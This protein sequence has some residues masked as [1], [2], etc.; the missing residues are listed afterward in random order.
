MMR[1]QANRDQ[2]KRNQAQRTAAQVATRAGAVEGAKEPGGFTLIE[3]LVA[4]AAVGLIAVGMASLFERTGDTVRAGRRLANLNEQALMIEKTLREDIEGMS[5]GG[6]LAIQHRLAPVRG[7]DLQPAEIALNTDDRGPR[8]RRIDSIMFFREGRFTTQR[9][10]VHPSRTAVGRAARVYYGHGLPQA[11]SQANVDAYT[12]ALHDTNDDGPGM[13]RAPGFGE[14][15]P[16]EF[17]GRWILLRHET[18]L[19]P[20]RLSESDEAARGAQFPR[21]GRWADSRF[22]IAL[23]PAAGDVFRLFS[24]YPEGAAGYPQALLPRDAELVRPVQGAGTGVPRFES[25]I[26]DIASTD[27]AAIRARVL[28]AQPI[29]YTD[30]ARAAALRDLE[31]VEEADPDNPGRTRPAP[32]ALQRPDL[33]P[34]VRRPFDVTRALAAGPNNSALA[35]RQDPARLGDPVGQVWPVPTAARM[36]AWMLDAFPADPYPV[37]RDGIELRV[38]CEPSPPDLLGTVAGGQAWPDDEPWRRTDQYMLSASNFVIGCTEF[39]VEWSYGNVYP[40][41]G[42]GAPA[43]PDLRGRMIWHG[44]PRAVDADGDPTT[45]DLLVAHPYN[46]ADAAQRVVFEEYD[47]DLNGADPQTGAGRYPRGFTDLGATGNRTS[48]HVF[49]TGLIHEPAPLTSNE[50]NF[51]DQNGPARGAET[52]LF[53]LFGYVDPTFGWTDPTAADVRDREPMPGE[54]SQAPVPWPKLIRVTMSLV[55]QSDPLREQSYQFVFRVPRGGE[56]AAR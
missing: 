17:A 35:V 46:S 49:E 51:P 56:D 22:Q 3:M 1:D 43:N 19:S 12:P 27:L 13:Q 7:D 41:T 30:A 5:R 40:T 10:P 16:S 2:A 45:A 4:V 8:A 31:R 42:P 47:A 39:I 28:G 26:V 14:A 52:R 48:K 15:G 9:E 20:P 32:F 53:S 29:G 6:F 38:R 54:P 11:L 44:L 21:A 24:A 18:V 23:Q 50:W 37:G 25:G 36:K 33:D 34:A 55:D